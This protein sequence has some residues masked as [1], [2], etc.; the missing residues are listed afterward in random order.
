MHT[1]RRVFTPFMTAHHNRE[2]RARMVGWEEVGGGGGRRPN[3]PRPPPPCLP[4]GEGREVRFQEGRGLP[5]AE[6]LLRKQLGQGAVLLGLERLPLVRRRLGSRRSTRECSGQ[7]AAHGHP[8]IVGYSVRMHVATTDMWRGVR[9]RVCVWAGVGGWHC[10][11]VGN[12]AVR[13]VG[14]NRREHHHREALDLGQGRW[15]HSQGIPAWN[16]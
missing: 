3:P 15:A 10:L 11:A 5:T 2:Q 16:M 9:V 7:G 4:H 13:R 1:H 14:T 12:L 6:V 8:R